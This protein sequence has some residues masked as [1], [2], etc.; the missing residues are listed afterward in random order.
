MSKIIMTNGFKNM[1]E[2]ADAGYPGSK[3]FSLPDPTVGL[4]QSQGCSNVAISR[5]CK[6]HYTSRSTRDGSRWHG[7][8]P[9]SRY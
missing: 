5:Y 2:W 4:C 7:L 6:K 8:K 9:T 1:K 3:S